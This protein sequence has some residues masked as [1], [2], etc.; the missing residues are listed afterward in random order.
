[1]KSLCFSFKPR[2]TP[3]AAQHSGMLEQC[4]PD[5]DGNLLPVTGKGEIYTARHQAGGRQLPEALST[6]LLGLPGTMACTKSGHG[7]LLM[8]RPPS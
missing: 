7:L 8:S 5:K 2:C 6:L 3:G 1:M 4:C